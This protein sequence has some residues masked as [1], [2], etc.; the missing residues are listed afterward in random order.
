[1]CQS[2]GDCVKVLCVEL[3][4]G[5]PMSLSKHWREC[6]HALGLP[7]PPEPE[8]VT[9]S[10][11]YAETHRAYHTLQH[12]EECFRAFEEVRDLAQ[13]PG[14]VGLALFYHDAIYDTHARDNEEK[15]AELACRVL[16][17]VGADSSLLQ[18]MIDLIL[19]TRH[20]AM[21]QTLDQ[22]LVV[23]VDLSILGAPKDRFDEYERQV[24]RE[25]DWVDEAIFR[26]VRS[27][28]LQEFLARPTIYSTPS[29]RDRLENLA[30]EN[31]KRSITRLTA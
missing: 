18:N 22:Q 6:F 3:V 15:S 14:A 23:D 19:V 1:M 27:R 2:Q 9:L 13:S 12:L 17:S 7:A 25:Y 8:F 24:R 31:L 26:L 4:C 30:H 28:I 20:A 16:S 29:F 10:A 11:R 21:P 5:V